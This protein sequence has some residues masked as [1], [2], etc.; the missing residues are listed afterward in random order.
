MPRFTISEKAVE[1]IN[2]IWVYTA[3]NWSI[4]QA[5]RYYKLIFDE[6]EYIAE[7]FESARDFG[8]VRKGYRYSKVKSHLI[9]FRKMKGGK[10]EVVRVLQQ[11]VDI[12]IG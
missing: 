11:L 10:I 5:D 6:I 3:E 2:S 8:E 12:E 9:F 7:N 1:D 4:K